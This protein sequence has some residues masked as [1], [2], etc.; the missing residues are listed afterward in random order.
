MPKDWGGENNDIFTGVTL[1]EGK[2]LAAFALKGP[3]ATGPLVQKMGTNG[4]NSAVWLAREL[5][6]VQ[7]EGQV[8]RKAFTS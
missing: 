2:R 8:Q 1:F 4:T 6:L 3:A 5:F 7:Y